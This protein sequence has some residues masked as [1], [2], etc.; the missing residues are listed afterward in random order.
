MLTLILAGA[1]QVTAPSAQTFD[2][3]RGPVAP[4]VGNSIEVRYG[5]QLMVTHF[6]PDGTFKMRTPDG[7]DATGDWVADDR[8]M[9]WITKTPSVPPGANLRCEGI[10]PGHNVGDTWTQTDSYGQEATVTLVAG[11]RLATR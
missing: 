10:V 8:H 11:D 4:L 7:V 9:C 6:A 3:A 5:D 2:R 1:L